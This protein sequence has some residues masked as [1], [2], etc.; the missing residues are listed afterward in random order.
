MIF[1]LI[2]WL[3][4]GLL[5]GLAARFFLPKNYPKGLLKTVCIGIIG[6]YFGGLIKWFL[7][8]FE[9]NF[10]PSGFIFSLI[11]SVLFLL[12]WRKLDA[13]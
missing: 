5:I 4:F 6:S 7:S 10:S 1:E 13:K 11:G 2:G 3:F 12:I 9:N 8:G